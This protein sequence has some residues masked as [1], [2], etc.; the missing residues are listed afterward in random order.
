MPNFQLH[1]PGDRNLLDEVSGDIYGINETLGITAV[2]AFLY[3]TTLDSDNGAWRYR[4]SHTS[5]EK[6]ARPSGAYL[7]FAVDEAG[8]RALLGADTGCYYY[9][10]SDSNFYSLSSV[11]GQTE[12]FR[13]TGQRFPVTALITFETA[14]VIIWDAEDGSMWMVANRGTTTW[15][16]ISYAADSSVSSLGM[17]N[18]KLVIGTTGLA[19]TR[20]GVTVADFNSDIASRYRNGESVY[21]GTISERST[22]FPDGGTNPTQILLV[23]GFINDVAITTLPNAPTDTATGLPVPTIAVATDA[24][25]SVIKDDRTVVDIV[26]TSSTVVRNIDFDENHNVW[27]LHGGNTS[28]ATNWRK[29]AIPE[30]DL[31]SEN[32]ASGGLAVYTNNT[33]PSLGNFP[34]VYPQTRGI[35]SNKAIALVDRLTHLAEDP[36][37]PANGMVAYTTADYAT[38]WMHGDIKGAFM[39]EASEDDLVGGE[40][41]TNGTFDTDIAGWTARNAVISHSAGKLVVDDT[42][43]AGADS[44]AYQTV[45]TV[46]GKTY[47]VELDVATTTSSA[48]LYVAQN[49]VLT[50]NQVL[51]SAQP[52]GVYSVTFTASTDN[53]VIFLITGGTGVTEF[54]S[55]SVKLAN[56]DRSVNN[57]GLATTG[58]ITVAP[59]ATGSETMAY[60]GYSATDYLEQPYNSDLDFGTGDFAF[61]FWYKNDGTG[62]TSY[63]IQRGGTGGSGIDFYLWR[64]SSS[65]TMK[66]NLRLVSSTVSSVT[67]SAVGVWEHWAAVRSSGIISWYRNGELDAS[68]AVGE[69]IGSD[70]KMDV[71]KAAYGSLSRIRIGAGAPTDEQIKK[72]YDTEKWHYRE[73]AKTLLD[74]SVVRDLSYDKAQDNLH[75]LTTT[76][77]S[78]F[79]NQSLTRVEYTA[80]DWNWITADDGRVA[81]G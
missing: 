58:T 49:S 43:N 40:L 79:D 21:L 44:A 20:A 16:W 22:E 13:G 72:I 74:S 24:G 3:D 55:V 77:H 37:T 5:W 46:A 71:C 70:Q 81:K 14:R 73:D 76:G 26:F 11:T 47:V 54:N 66:M 25:V 56:E 39:C 2:G 51:L 75:V 8:A 68:L 17:S 10:T 31:L 60:S 34:A 42:L 19:E 50:G 29:Y 65:G 63:I 69:T 6:E 4:C 45:P 28:I 38:G 30:A 52:V 64:S 23:N 9:N 57:N 18:G 59:A 27:F 53:M 15:T 61:Y 48:F 67:P 7:G 32:L 41:V 1:R 62:S 36:T 33:S 12:V 78:V 80:G 35:V